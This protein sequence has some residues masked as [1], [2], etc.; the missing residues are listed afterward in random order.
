MGDSE[1]GYEDKS[2][3]INAGEGRHSVETWHAN[4]LC[5]LS[6]VLMFSISTLLTWYGKPKFVKAEV[7]FWKWR[8]IFISW[9]HGV[10]VGPWDLLW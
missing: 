5:A 1:Y 8:N 3:I 7:D 10:I 6:T 9:I 2:L 4:A